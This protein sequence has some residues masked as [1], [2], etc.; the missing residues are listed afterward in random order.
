[1]DSQCR[2]PLRRSRRGHNERLRR[3]SL[4]YREAGQCGG[5]QL[6][7]DSGRRACNN[8]ADRPRGQLR[9]TQDTRTSKHTATSSARYSLRLRPTRAQ[10]SSL[11]STSPTEMSLSPL[12]TMRS[13]SSRPP[14]F[15]LTK[16]SKLRTAGWN[17]DRN[18]LYGNRNEAFAFTLIPGELAPEIAFGGGT[19]AKGSAGEDSWEYPSMQGS[20]R[21]PKAYG[22][23]PYERSDRLYHSGQ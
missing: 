9:A 12:T 2:Y 21:R 1:M 15:S 19:E 8:L 11:Y 18:R 14:D 3:L 17:P 13:S 16:R 4:F 7:S 23:R 20:R 5:R 22:A 6:C 10:G